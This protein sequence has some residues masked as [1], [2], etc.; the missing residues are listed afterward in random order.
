MGGSEGVIKQGHGQLITA[1]C[2]GRSSFIDGD[3]RECGECPPL[4]ERIRE[5]FKE[6]VMFEVGPEEWKEKEKKGHEGGSKERRKERK[7][8]KGI[9]STEKRK[10]IKMHRDFV[11]RQES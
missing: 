10:D 4:P 3:P 5:G 8:G 1:R 2:H 6:E 9:L 11:K 7:K